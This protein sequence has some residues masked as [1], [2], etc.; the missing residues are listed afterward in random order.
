MSMVRW[1]LSASVVCALVGCGPAED[2]PDA[3]V[4]FFIAQQ[5][6]FADYRSWQQ[7]TV[8]DL[9]LDEPGDGGTDADGGT[10]DAGEHGGG[11]HIAY[12]NHVP[13]SGSQ[14]FPT[15]TIIVKE[16]LDADGQPT[17]R[18]HAM[19]KRNGGFNAQG[20]FGWEWFELTPSTQGVP[21]IRWRGAEPPNGSGYVDPGT[22]NPAGDCNKCHGVAS[23][24]DY[25][26]SKPLRLS[27]F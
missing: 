20:A 21:V 23:T 4:D 6:D 10:V 2:K 17:D 18:I 12:I 1:A 8:A 24:N 25:V 19:V 22:T 26:Q 9:P 15:G 14:L 7:Y 13:E 16:A 5:S 11:K 3:G 27:S